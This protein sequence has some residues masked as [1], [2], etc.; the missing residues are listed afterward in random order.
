MERHTVSKP[1]AVVGK[2]IEVPALDAVSALPA[3]PAVAAPA[4]FAA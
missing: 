3:M 4:T 1:V 2:A